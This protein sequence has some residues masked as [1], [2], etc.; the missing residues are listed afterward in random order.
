MTA[1]AEYRDLARRGFLSRTVMFV[2]ALAFVLQSFV[3]QTH[4]HLGAQD[5]A[6]IAQI[7]DAAPVSVH[8]KPAHDRG[9]IECPFCQVI[10]VA[11]VFIGAAGP[12]LHL[13]FVWVVTQ[14]HAFEARSFSVQ[15]VHS[16][17]SRAPPS[18]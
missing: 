16:W 12:A 1:A 3:T 15:I 18:L 7:G 13:P 14:V 11:G 6:G 10:A 17:Q 4:I 8:G 2:A 9:P 5:P